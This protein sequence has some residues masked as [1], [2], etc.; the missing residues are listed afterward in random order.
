M[1]GPLVLMR[2]KLC[3]FL[4]EIVQHAAT[5]RSTTGLIERKGEGKKGAAIFPLDSDR[6]H[7]NWSLTSCCQSHWVHMTVELGHK[8]IALGHHMTV[9]LG[10]K[11]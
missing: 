2:P 9:E 8:Q 1:Y 5:L 11:Q 10:H 7:S 6:V 3:I 4:S